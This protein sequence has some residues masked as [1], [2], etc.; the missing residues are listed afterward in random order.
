MNYGKRGAAK[1]KKALR[2]KSKKWSKRFALTFFKAI[3]LLSAQV[4]GRQ[5]HDCILTGNVNMH[6]DGGAHE[7]SKKYH[8]VQTL[9]MT[10]VMFR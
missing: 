3:L 10:N 1:K 2:S 5:N 8:L 4:N 6:M 9:K 7:F